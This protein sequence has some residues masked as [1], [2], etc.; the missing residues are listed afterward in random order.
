M[1]VLQRRSG[2]TSSLL[3]QL[4]GLGAVP[5]GVLGKANERLVKVTLSN[6]FQADDALKD[7]ILQGGFNPR[8][9]GKI[10]QQFSR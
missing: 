6:F 10:S 7:L 9:G 4:D 3:P 5:N 8:K 1:R 2:P